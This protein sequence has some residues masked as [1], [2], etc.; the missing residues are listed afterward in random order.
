MTQNVIL[1]VKNQ[2]KP[3]LFYVMRLV[4]ESE[5]KTHVQPRILQGQTGV[6]CEDCLKVQTFR[7][8]GGDGEYE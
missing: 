8:L 3:A 4:S 7:S 2:A 6:N 1:C 5:L